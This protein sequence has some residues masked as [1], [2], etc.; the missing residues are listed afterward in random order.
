LSE[1]IASSGI[2]ENFNT[3][4]EKFFLDNLEKNIYDIK[5]SEFEVPS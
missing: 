2:R 3:G 4:C 1:Q 5:G